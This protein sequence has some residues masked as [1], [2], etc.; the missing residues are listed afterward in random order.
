MH[1]I[2]N[3]LARNAFF[4][5]RSL[6]KLL[7][8]LQ[9]MRQFIEDDANLGGKAITFQGDKHA[10]ERLTNKDLF[11]GMVGLLS[12]I[13][14]ELRKGM[15]EYRGTDDFKPN[16]MKAIFTDKTLKLDGSS[17]RANGDEQFVAYRDWYIFDAN[18]GTS[19]EKNFVR[20]LEGQMDYLKERCDEIFLARNERHFKIYNF[21]DGQAFEPDFVLFLCKKNGDQLTYQLFI[22][23]KG[24][25]LVVHESWKQEFL[26][27]LKER[28]ADEMLVL[29]LQGKKQS[30][31]LIGMP[32]Y[33]RT[34]EN[35]FIREL[36]ETLSIAQPASRT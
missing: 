29:E 12:E 5:F 18:Y 36:H 35:E 6:N 3:A 8:N 16:S 34:R 33:N 22:E 24:E 7:P 14:T 10:L 32:F 27:K 30:Y 20:A 9:S 2:K 26:Q 28:F 13:E 11:D 15:T 25:H 21:V 31:Q 4:T 1:I 17:E 23:P 19:E